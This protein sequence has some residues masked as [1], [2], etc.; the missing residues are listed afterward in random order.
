MSRQRKILIHVLGHLAG[1]GGY[2]AVAYGL[3]AAYVLALEQLFGRQAGLDDPVFVTFVPAAACVIG[4]V[5]WFPIWVGLWVYGGFARWF[6]ILV[7]PA[8]LAALISLPLCGGLSRC[9]VPGGT[10]HMVGF[11]LALT[12]GLG[13]VAHHEIL[14]WVIRVLSPP[15][16]SLHARTAS[17]Q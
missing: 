4:I 15:P 17:G 13:A 3:G 14:Q 12:V 7:I 1:F 2:G 16:P 6:G 9:F 8:V 10:E 11:V 5:V